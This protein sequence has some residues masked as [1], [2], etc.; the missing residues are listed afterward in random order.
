MENIHTQETWSILHLI[1]DELKHIT[2]VYDR[3]QMLILHINIHSIT[4]ILDNIL[5]SRLYQMNIEIHFVLIQ[6]FL[7]NNTAKLYYILG[8]TMIYKNR[9]IGKRGGVALYKINHIF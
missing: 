9:R 8:Y 7:T 1:V 4:A 2:Y 6:T 5:I 3:I